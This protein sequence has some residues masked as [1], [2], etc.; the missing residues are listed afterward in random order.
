MGDH[1]ADGSLRVVLWG[2]PSSFILSGAEMYDCQKL[3]SELKWKYR[4][5]GEAVYMKWQ[6][7]KRKIMFLI[8]FLVLAL[9]MLGVSLLYDIFVNRQQGNEM[10]DL[11]SGEIVELQLVYAYQNSQWNSAIEN[12]IK[13]FGKEH[14]D[15]VIQYEINYEDTVYEDLLSKRVARN[16][17]GDIVQLKTPEAYAASGL[18]GEISGDVAEQVSSVYEYDGRIYGVGAVE[19]TW[20]ILYNKTLFDRYGLKEPETYEDFLDICG[21]LS[22]R[23]ITPVGVAGEDLWHMEF[24]VNHFFRTDVLKNDPD[25]LKKCEAGQVRWTDEA[26]RRMMDHLCQLFETGYVN[27]DWMASADTGLSYDMSQGEFAMIYTGPWT[28]EAIEKLQPEMEL[29]W[30]YVPDEN[31]TVCASDNLDTF[32][33]VTAACA[34]DPEKYEA[35]MTFLNYFYSQDAYLEV[36]EDSSAFPLTSAQ[37]QYEEGSFMEDVW[38]SFESADQ[39]ISTYIGN[40]NTPEEFEKSMLEIV[41]ETLNGAWTSREGLERIQGVWELC[42]G[43]E[44]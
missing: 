19:S 14:Q 15:I 12:V 28:A 1:P 13:S 2:L 42:S 18:L 40:E 4:L 22:R 6:K 9:L 32:W 30:F 5:I 37:I 11:S 21:Y 20:G 8:P 7:K 24:W 36:C 43:G 41:Q 39:K 17:L 23:D 25:W 44:S 38:N 34:E 26:P 33:S 27:D 16:E 10:E 29:G 35:A 3:Y 31:G